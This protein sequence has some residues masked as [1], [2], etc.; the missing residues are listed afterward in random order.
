MSN[1]VPSGALRAVLQLL[2]LLRPA[3]AA[4]YRGPVQP[5][6]FSGPGPAAGAGLDDFGKLGAVADQVAEVLGSLDARA[7]F[8]DMVGESRAMRAAFS[9]RR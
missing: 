3:S 2:A 6:V 5:R 8:P 9:G 1:L 4:A 7:L